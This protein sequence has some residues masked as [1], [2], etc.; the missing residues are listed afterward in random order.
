M[1]K[2]KL[3]RRVCSE[4]MTHSNAAR[5]I[6]FL[7]EKFGRSLALFRNISALLKCQCDPKAWDDIFQSFSSLKGCYPIW[8]KLLYNLRNSILGKQVSQSHSR[9]FP[10]IGIAQSELH[11]IGIIM[12]PQ[13]WEMNMEDA[14][15]KLLEPPNL[16]ELF[17]FFNL[18]DNVNRQLT[19]RLCFWS[20]L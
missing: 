13:S 4:Q 5:I 17:E 12:Y 19:Y 16:Q 8:E 18:N 20:S 11:I 10:W 9:N 15:S 14:F 6:P 2:R 7:K 1:K 3:T